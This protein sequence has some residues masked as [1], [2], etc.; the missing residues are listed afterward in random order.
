MDLKQMVGPLPLGG[1]L[2]VGAVSIGTLYWRKNHSVKTTTNT[3]TTQLTPMTDATVGNIGG[4][5]SLM[6]LVG[7]QGGSGHNLQPIQD[8]TDWYRQAMAALIG[9]GWSA[10]LADSALRK[11]M[12]GMTLTAEES[13][14]VDSALQLVGPMPSP[15]PPPTGVVGNPTPTPVG[16]RVNPDFNP[17]TMNNIDLINQGGNQY[18]AGWGYEPFANE[19]VTRFGNGLSVNDP[20]FL[21]PDGT[22]KGLWYAVAPAMNHKLG[23]LGLSYPVNS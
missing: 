5:K 20:N 21:K 18:E 23:G 12:Q 7:A 19:I 3:P 9:K 10:T 4:L 8:N 6:D 17:A 1:W 11:Y 14:M 22:P 13:A 2:G 16:P 15:A